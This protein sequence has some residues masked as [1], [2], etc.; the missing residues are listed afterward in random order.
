MKLKQEYNVK[1]FIHIS[2]VVIFGNLGLHVQY[3]I[4][5]L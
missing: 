2:G 5:F 4:V 1:I 3:C